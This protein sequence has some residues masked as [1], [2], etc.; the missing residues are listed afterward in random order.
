[1]FCPKCGC[2]QE[3]GAKFCDKCG[4]SISGEPA[5]KPKKSGGGKAKRALTVVG[6]LA[7]LAVVVVGITVKRS[8]FSMAWG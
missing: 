8:Y 4:A 1:M 5:E 2:E 3:E 6:T 7:V